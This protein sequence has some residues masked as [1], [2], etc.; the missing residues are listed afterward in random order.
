MKNTCFELL[1]KL[2]QKRYQR[3]NKQC[4]TF[5][6]TITTSVVYFQ[7]NKELNNVVFV[8]LFLKNVIQLCV[9]TKPTTC[10]YFNKYR[11]FIFI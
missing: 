2:V 10:L 1:N 7:K 8:K 5:K 4:I 6:K 9:N 11:L 3:N